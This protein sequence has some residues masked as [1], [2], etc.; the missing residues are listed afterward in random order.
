MKENTLHRLVVQLLTQF[1]APGVIWYH[2]ANGE[3]RDIRTA[4]RLNTMGV[5]PG[6]PDLAFVL[7][8]GRAA[9]IELKSDKGRMRPEQVTFQELCAMTGAPYAVVRTFE[10]AIKVLR[11]WSVIH[12]RVATVS[13]EGGS[14]RA[15]P[16]APRSAVA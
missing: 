11:D 4:M 8:D 14:R 10:E 5:R 6:V 12:V 2:P 3:K 7:A 15:N 16:N 13:V 1:A 9:F